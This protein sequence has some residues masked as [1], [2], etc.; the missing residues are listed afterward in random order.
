MV[1]QGQCWEPLLSCRPARRLLLKSH[2]LPWLHFYFST[3]LVRRAG[4]RPFSWAGFV[5]L[6][7]REELLAPGQG[8]RVSVP[9]SLST[10]RD[11]EMRISPP[12]EDSCCY[13]H[14]ALPRIALPLPGPSAPRVLRAN[15]A[16]GPCYLLSKAQHTSRAVLDGDHPHA[17]PHVFPGASTSP[18]GLSYTDP[19][20]VPM[21]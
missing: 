8:W 14:P 19:Y 15:C 3:L 7:G 12:F 20:S 2:F 9:L 17:A 5:Q 13:L 6:P 4:Q 10:P 1:V 16:F 11:A 21:S 18:Q